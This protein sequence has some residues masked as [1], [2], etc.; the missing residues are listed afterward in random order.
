MKEKKILQPDKE[1]F[2]DKI[3]ILS[4]DDQMLPESLKIAQRL[5]QN[6]FPTDFALGRKKLKKALSF[7]ASKRI[8]YVI[9]IGP[10]EI[11]KN[12]LAVRDL[13]SEEQVVVPIEKIVEYFKEKMRRP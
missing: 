2:D 11:I 1:G 12:E 6:D 8:R 3:M 13:A 9:I 10:D 5:R 4:I 7:A